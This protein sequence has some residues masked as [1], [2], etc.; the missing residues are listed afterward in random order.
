M[1]K[2]WCYNWKAFCDAENN[3]KNWVPQKCF[4]KIWNEL[5]SVTRNI[6]KL[7]LIQTLSPSIGSE[8]YIITL[9]KPTKTTTK[10]QTCT[11]FF[12]AAMV[13][14]VVGI[15]YV[16]GW[17]IG[18][19]EAISLSILV[20]SSVDYCVHLVEG[21]ILAGA[22]CPIKDVCIRELRIIWIKFDVWYMYEV[23]MVNKR[24]DENVKNCKATTKIMWLD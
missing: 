12:F 17:E 7:S 8:I 22:A 18:G 19:V 24:E 5:P 16:V 6:R 1:N 3:S 4:C 21:Y 11:C 2:K 20:G 15:F 23:R 10:L 14:L 13:C 9:V